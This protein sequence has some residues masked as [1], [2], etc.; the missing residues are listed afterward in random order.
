MTSP[1]TDPIR[2]VAVHGVGNSFG[3]DIYGTRLEELRTMKAAVWAQQ[4][5]SGLGI[6]RDRVNLDFA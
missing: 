6:A 2:I 4:L 3:A 5:S 1:D